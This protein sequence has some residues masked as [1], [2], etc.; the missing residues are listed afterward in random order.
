MTSCDRERVFALVYGFF[1]GTEAEA[2]RSHVAACGDCRRLALGLEQ[3]K[4]ALEG[5]LSSPE[6]GMGP[7]G[8]SPRLHRDLA[9]RSVPRPAPGRTRIVRFAALA[10]AACAVVS[11]GVRL[12]ASPRPIATVARV[13]G[14][15]AIAGRFR[16]LVEGAPI[17]AGD[18]IDVPAGAHLEVAF[19]GGIRLVLRQRS[20]AEAGRPSPGERARIRLETGAAF[21]DVPVAGRSVVVET[22]HGRTSSLGTAWM[23]VAEPSRTVCAVLRGTVAFEG[24]GARIEVKAGAAAVAGAGRAPAPEP[25]VDIERLA[26]WRRGT[27]AFRSRPLRE[28]LAWIASDGAYRFQGFE[29]YGDRTITAAFR[30]ETA[31]EMVSAVLQAAGIPYRIRGAVVSPL[32]A[33]PPSGGTR[34]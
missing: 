16:P 14:A 30:D 7:A 3:E 8:A 33:P 17:H 24:S 9:R 32:A 5:A 11:V 6:A 18:R 22:A 4:A 1:S 23:V 12:L 20:R 26:A 27:T 25:D 29:G 15:P 2:A 21:V 31:A 10:A 19:A 13:E 34:R 28:V